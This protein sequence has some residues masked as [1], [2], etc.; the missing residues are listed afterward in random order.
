MIYIKRPNF[1]PKSLSNTLVYL[2]IGKSQCMKYKTFWKSLYLLNNQQ[3]IT[4]FQILEA[5]NN[6]E[7]IIETIEFIL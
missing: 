3:K 1:F 4:Q 5:L 6:K 2:K 7:T